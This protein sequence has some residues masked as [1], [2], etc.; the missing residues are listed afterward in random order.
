MIVKS[1]KKNERAKCWKMT[2]EK[3]G[4]RNWKR[5]FKEPWRL[6]EED[7]KQGGLFF[8]EKDSIGDRLAACSGFSASIASGGASERGWRDHREFGH[9]KRIGRYDCGFRYCSE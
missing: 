7:D 2:F 8:E 5:G 4:C 1:L 3:E 6:T 9:C